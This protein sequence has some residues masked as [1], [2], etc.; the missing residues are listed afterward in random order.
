MRSKKAL[1]NVVSSLMLQ[2]VSVVCGFIVPRM[3]IGTYGSAVNGMMTSATQF[4]SYIYLLESGAGG[5]IR[6]ALY[7]P[8]S[9]GNILGVSAIVKASE[10]FFRTVAA[11]FA[12]YA[13]VLAC[14]FPL[15]VNGDFEWLYTFGMVLIIG[16]S[17]FVQYYF[18]LSNQILIHADQKNYVTSTLQI[19]TVILN[20]VIAVVMIRSGA[21]VHAVKLASSLIF[22]LRPLTLHFYVRKKYSLPKDVTP[23]KEA[24]S[25]RFDGLGHHIAFFLHT[26]TDVVILTVFAKLSH[27]ATV[28]EVSV[29]GV[30]YAVVSG[31]Q[32]LTSTL[33]SGI[34][35]TFG[36]M[37]AKNETEALKR[38]FSLYEFVTFT[39]AAVVFTCTGILIVPF[40]SVYT[41]SITDI[42]YIRPLFAYMLTLSEA[43]FCIRIPYNSVTLAAGHYRQTRNGAMAEAGINIALSAAL[44][45]PFGLTGVAVGTLAAMSFRTVQYVFYLSK[46]ILHRSVMTFFVRLGVNCLFSVLSIFLSTLIP[47][48]ANNYLTWALYAVII[49]GVCAFVIV[50]ANILFYR[51]DFRNL[52]AMAKRVWRVKS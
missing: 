51:D 42:N 9:A 1:K 5:V 8:L 28:A 12:L 15:L 38:N 18:G 31:V 40:I 20:A 37:L 19:V 39:A 46:N 47:D 34:E 45:A 44:V 50:P 10:R 27:A 35:A 25:Q 14:A 13:L 29:Y 6:A 2:V 11:V 16:A 22:A 36:D 49:L 30:Y 41:R 43:V 52:L 7:K 4:L 17:T 33:S 26:N 24:I 32:K 21:S 23:D 3:I 48:F